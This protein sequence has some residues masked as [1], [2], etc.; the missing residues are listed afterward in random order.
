MRISGTPNPVGE[1][2]MTLI[3]RKGIDLDPV[4]PWNLATIPGRSKP[5]EIISYPDP[6]GTVFA[7]MTVGDPT[8][9]RYVPL[10]SIAA[11][12]P[13]RLGADE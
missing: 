2:T 10:K 12:S 3:Q 5:V 9:A 1:T 6:D 11:F 7:R 13:D 8:S 4:E